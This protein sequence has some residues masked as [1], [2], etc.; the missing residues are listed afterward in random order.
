MDICLY[1][2]EIPQNLGTILRL[3]ACMG[4]GIKVIEPCGFVVSDR[5]LQ[6]SGMDYIH[7]VAWELIPSWEDFLSRHSQGRIIALTPQASIVYTDFSF[8]ADDILLLGREGDGIP[9]SLL[10]TLQYQVSIPMCNNMRSLNVAVAGAM[11]LGEAL[12]QTQSLSTFD[13]I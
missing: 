10:D 4:V 7:H 8:Q 3:G 6:R 9:P 12:R 1:Q 5:R 2:P 11:V 13:S